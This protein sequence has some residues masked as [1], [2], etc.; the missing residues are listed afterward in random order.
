MSFGVASMVAP[1]LR[2]A[3]A[4]PGRAMLTADRQAWHYGPDFDPARVGDE[5]AVFVELLR[6]SGAEILTIDTDHSA[7]AD[8]VFTYDASLMTPAGAILMS[9]G[10][11]MRQGEEQLHAAFYRAENIPVVGAISGPA[12]A[13]AGDTL[14]LDENTLVIG[15]G[16]RTN[17]AGLAQLS[18]MMAA[19]GVDTPSFDL[20]TYGGAAACLHLMSLISLLD[21][22][23]ALICKPLLP[24]GLLQLLE[25]REF[26]LIEAPFDEFE[27]TGTLSTNV[28][29]TR[30]GKCIMLDDI[31][32][33]RAA[34][35]DAGIAVSV[36]H[37]NA[38]C[39]GCEGGPTCMTRPILRGQAA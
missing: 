34:I 22:R 21:A 9:P 12:R 19:Q 32:R 31:P 14:W 15:R 25:A 23:T 39:I 37:G 26:R 7:I 17:A 11:A 28:L 38:L 20:P 6:R 8:A 30:P 16:F 33:T 27:A 4:P 24:V 13:E 36:F 10:K 1:L 35:E 5:H 29:T 2:V 18:S 3:V